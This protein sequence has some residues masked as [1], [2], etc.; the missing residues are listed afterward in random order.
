MLWFVGVG[1]DLLESVAVFCGPQG[2][3]EVC[4]GLLRSA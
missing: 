2:S 1:K 4:R 3:V